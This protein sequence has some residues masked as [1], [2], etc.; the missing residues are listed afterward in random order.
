MR[1]LS[2]VSYCLPKWF[3]TVRN[4]WYD[5]ETVL[6]GNTKPWRGFAPNFNCLKLFVIDSGHFFEFF[7]VVRTE[8]K[9][10]PRIETNS[11]PFWILCRTFFFQCSLVEPPSFLILNN[12]FLIVINFCP[13]FL[14]LLLF[15]I[16][17]CMSWQLDW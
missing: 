3:G 8:P 11:K 7:L 17:V 2:R 16:V 15:S 13:I 12:H 4:K 9:M 1:N 5:Y 14:I 10:V 6:V